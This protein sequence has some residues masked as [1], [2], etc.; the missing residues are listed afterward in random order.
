MS[1]NDGNNDNDDVL[2]MVAGGLF[3]FAA[4]IGV[5]LGLLAALVFAVRCA[6]EAGA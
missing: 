1:G 3:F 2:A 5:G 4:L 6:W